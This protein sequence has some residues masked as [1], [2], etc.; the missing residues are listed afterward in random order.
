ME[1]LGGSWERGSLDAMTTSLPRQSYPRTGP[2]F[3]HASMPP[4]RSQHEPTAG[5][6]VAKQDNIGG[7]FTHCRASRTLA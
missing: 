7:A 1:G 2:W 6:A 5:A 4:K 3:A